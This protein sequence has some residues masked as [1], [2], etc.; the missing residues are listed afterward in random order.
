MFSAADKLKCVVRE[1]KLR[2]RV[3]ARRVA[4]GI[5]HRAT[6]AHEIEVMEEIVKDYEKRVEEERLI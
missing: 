6:A 1:L 2:H 3:Y 5:M 4:A